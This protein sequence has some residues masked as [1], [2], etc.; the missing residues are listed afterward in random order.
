[1][2]RASVIAMLVAIEIAII[3]VAFYAVGGLHWNGTGWSGQA[4]ASMQNVDFAAKP[5]API[6]AGSTPRV[7]I[8]DPESRVVVKAAS[9]GRVHVS[10]LTSVSGMGF[11]GE[12]SIPQLH[13]TRTADGISIVRAWHAPFLV[14]GSVDE[15]IDVDVPAGSLVEISRCEGADVSDIA[16]GVSVR[17]QDGHVTLARLRGKVDAQSD[18]GYI[19]AS[20]I[21]GDSL[22][23]RTSDGHLA[24]RDVALKTLEA[25]TDD[26][27]VRV[28]RLSALDN[29]TISSDNGS[30]ELELAAGADLTVDA[31]TAD[32][33]ISVNGST[34]ESGDSDSVRH[35]ISFGKGTGALRVSTSDGSIH[36]LTNGAQ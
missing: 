31:S 22:R 36:I 11:S 32:G 1:V 17:S 18:D 19:E 8:D 7:T 12:S 5:I 15:R 23:M 28:E 33:S 2:S 6:T 35:T 9:D 3:A 13:V 34:V 4:F 14:F 25:H 10:D 21:Y 16:G 30:I 20:N 27:R 29:G 24:L 26:G